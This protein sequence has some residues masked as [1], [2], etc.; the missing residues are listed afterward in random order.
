MIYRQHE[1]I[2][3]QTISEE[4]TRPKEWDPQ[5]D[6]IRL[7]KTSPEYQKVESKMTSTMPKVSEC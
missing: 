1:I 6:N 3:K 2:E 7:K 4:V 5:D